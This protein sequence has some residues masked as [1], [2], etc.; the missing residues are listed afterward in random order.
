MKNIIL[1]AVAA[2]I[3]FGAAVIG[4]REIPVNIKDIFLF[5]AVVGA[6]YYAGKYSSQT[7]SAIRKFNKARKKAKAKAAEF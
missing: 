7:F 6:L 2:I 4:Y 1:S 3:L 5:V